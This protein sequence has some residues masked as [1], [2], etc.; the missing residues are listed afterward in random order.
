MH[1]EGTSRRKRTRVVIERVAAP[2][3]HTE[4][5]HTVSRAVLRSLRFDF[6]VVFILIG[7]IQAQAQTPFKKCEIGVP[8]R[9]RGVKV[10][11]MST[12]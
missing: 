7:I 5:L 11:R 6:I 4:I 9:L 2:L 3:N 8:A 1:A 12:K 10:E